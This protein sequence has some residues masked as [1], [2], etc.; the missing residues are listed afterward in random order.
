M[1]I[2][3]HYKSVFKILR[4]ICLLLGFADTAGGEGGTD[5][6]SSI[7]IQTVLCVIDS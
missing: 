6:E 4:V 5:W 1:R 2:M 3:C 7:D